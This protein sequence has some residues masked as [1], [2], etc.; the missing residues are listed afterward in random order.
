MWPALS[1]VDHL[2]QV[3]P[4]LAVSNRNN[5]GLIPGSGAAQLAG[6]PMQAQPLGAPGDRA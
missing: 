3:V 5:P 4:E 2:I 1:E 6:V